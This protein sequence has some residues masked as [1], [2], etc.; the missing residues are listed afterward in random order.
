MGLKYKHDWRFEHQWEA[1]VAQPKN[2]ILLDKFL[3]YS[4]KKATRNFQ[5]YTP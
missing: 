5:T 1:P 2:D 3:S 4:C